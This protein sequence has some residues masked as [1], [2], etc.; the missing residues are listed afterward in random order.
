MNI[1]PMPG[2]R[3]RV[4]AL[5]TIGAVPMQGSVGFQ[6]TEYYTMGV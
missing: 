3:T 6:G 5:G 2:L 1:C 4:Q